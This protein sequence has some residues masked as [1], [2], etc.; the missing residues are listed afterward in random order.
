M[1][2]FNQ[3][4]AQTKVDQL[5]KEIGVISPPVPV[6]K[7][8]KALGADVRRAVLHDELSGFLYRAKGNEIII[9]VNSSHAPVRQRFTIAHEIAHLLLHKKS[10]VY[11]DRDFSLSFRNQDSSKANL[12]S[13]ME[14]NQFAAELLM[15]RQ[16]LERDLEKRKD[17]LLDEQSLLV[18]AKRYQVSQQALKIRLNSPGLML[19]SD[20]LRTNQKK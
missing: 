18:F 19:P 16:F 4:I 5:L 17:G 8:A 3:G 1:V 11:V 9:G 7:L 14:A 20:L 10:P 15:P 13:E 2:S 6:E 12:R